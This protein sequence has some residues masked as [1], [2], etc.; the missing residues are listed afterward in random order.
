M[1][2]TDLKHGWLK[3]K[4]NFWFILG[5]A[6]RRSLLEGASAVALA[7]DLAML[8]VFAVILV[9]LS[10]FAFSAALG[11]ARRDGSLGRY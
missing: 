5:H 11:A 3:K 6:M 1:K 9:P 10:V 4:A 8:A 7:S 2:K